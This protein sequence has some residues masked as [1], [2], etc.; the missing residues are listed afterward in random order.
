[1]VSKRSWAQMGL[2]MFNVYIYIKACICVDVHIDRMLFVTL[3]V[4]LYINGTTDR[5]MYIY[6]VYMIT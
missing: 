5:Y 6:T 4:L 1:M 2:C 3:W